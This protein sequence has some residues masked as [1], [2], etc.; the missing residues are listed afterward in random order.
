MLKHLLAGL[1][2]IALCTGMSAASFTPLSNQQVCGKPSD[3]VKVVKKFRNDAQKQ[4][5]MGAPAKA[6]ALTYPV[7]LDFQVNEGS[8]VQIIIF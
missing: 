6:D 4:A 2:A 5:S 7:K 3:K 1:G 8:E